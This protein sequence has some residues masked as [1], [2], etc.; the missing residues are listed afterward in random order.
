[1]LTTLSL[2]LLSLSSTTFA[3]SNC[4]VSD[5]NW[6]LLAFGFDGKDYSLGTQDG[7]SSGSPTEITA[8]GR[9]PFDGENVTCWLAQYFN[10]VY[11][12][13]ADK[14]TPSNLY[15]YDAAGKSWSTQAT[16]PNNFDPTS[17]TGVLDHDTNVIYAMSKGNLF[18]LNMLE[19][20]AAQPDAIEWKDAGAPSFSTD[21]YEPVMGLAQNHVHFIGAPGLQDG[22]ANIYVIHYSYFQPEAQWYGGYFP[23]THGQAV[24]IFRDNTQTQFAYIPDSPQNA[25]VIDVTNNQTSTLPPPS[26]IDAKAN[27]F[28]TTSAIVQLTSAGQL[29]FIPYDVAN[30]KGGADAWAPVSAFASVAPTTSPSSSTSP[31]S[32]GRSADSTDVSGASGSSPVSA[33]GGVSSGTPSA[34]GG[35][36]A[37]GLQSSVF[38]GAAAFFTALFI[39]L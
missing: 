39:T 36:G 24:T 27:Y 10:V 18:S 38:M 4:V 26:T 23:E 34:D 8:N 28:A 30:F 13:G 16:T 7:W 11:V 6:N 35:D 37:L 17:F 9:P 33:P 31:S 2:L 14:N 19:L 12:L 21:G 29:N 25:Y 15:I 3:L 32:T 1:M 5:A 22:N 20:A